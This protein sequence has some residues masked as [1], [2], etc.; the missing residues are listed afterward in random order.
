MAIR[1]YRAVVDRLRCPSSSWMVRTSVPDSSKC[2]AN[3]C[4]RECGV[5]GLVMPAMRRANLHASSTAD[6]VIG[7][8]GRSPG[9]S[10][11]YRAHGPPVATQRVQQPGRQH[12]VAVFLS[13]TLLHVDDH[14]LTVDRSWLQVDRFRDTK[15]GCIA[16]GQDR[17][18][19][20]ALYQ[21]RSCRTSSGLS[22]AGKVCGFLQVGMTSSRTQSLLRVTL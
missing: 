22:T 4:R 17:A 18:L 8:P 3:A 13:F 7:C 14:P 15:T 12:H 2:T 19:F 11:S 20:D 21:S 9:N 6:L 16:G 10:H 5:T 1:R